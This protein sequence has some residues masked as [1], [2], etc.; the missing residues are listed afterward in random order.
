MPWPNVATFSDRAF[1]CCT[2]A[3]KAKQRLVLCQVVDYRS[4]G[5]QSKSLNMVCV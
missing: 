1:P 5:G 3:G 4:N 2:L